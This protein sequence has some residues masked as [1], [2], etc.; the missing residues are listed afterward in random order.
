M[1]KPITIWVGMDV[2]KNTIALHWLKGDTQKGEEREIPNTPAIIRRFFQRLR[3]EGAVRSCYEAG[4]CGYELRRQLDRMKVSCEVIA[5]SLIPRSRADR[6]KTD[7]RDARKLAR[8]YRAGELTPIHVPTEEGEAVR[9]LVRCREDMG[10]DV[11]R[12]RHR[13]L[14]FLLRHGRVWRET[15]HWSLAHW[16]WL[17]E[18]KFE[19]AAAQQSF[20]E[21]LARFQHSIERRSELDKQLKTISEQEPWKAQVDPLRCLR[22]V[23][24]LTAMTLLVEIQDFRRFRSPKELMSFV[25]LTPG[26]HSSGGEGYRTPITKNGNGHARRIV[27]EAAW[28]YRRKPAP[29]GPVAKR[30]RGQPLH[31][32]THAR[33]A[34]RRL[35]EKYHRL[36]CRGKPSQVAAIAVARELVGF[37]WAILV[38]H[39]EAEPVEATPVK[40]PTAKKTGLVR[41]Y[42]IK[43]QLQGVGG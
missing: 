13:L 17:R 37:I 4:P 7:R 26:I 34:Q 30:M 38:K 2:H 22:G 11:T 35:Y 29:G 33:K 36:V 31:V 9:D 21:Y 8:L 5:P 27:L 42:A 28:H 10:Q 1:Q 43:R 41:R 39:T 24:T 15:R 20:D 23:D 18:Q 3:K 14:K 19:H 32:Q 16:R 6:I 25:G 40:T 12:E